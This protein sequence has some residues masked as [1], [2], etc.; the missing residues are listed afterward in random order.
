M[1]L[2]ARGKDRFAQ[3]LQ[4]VTFCPPSRNATGQ[5]C[6]MATF[7][8]TVKYA[9]PTGT[10]VSTALLA[11]GVELQ[12]PQSKLTH[13]WIQAAICY[14][15][16]NW[17]NTSVVR[18][19]EEAVGKESTRKKRLFV[20]LDKEIIDGKELI[21]WHLSSKQI[22]WP[23]SF[24]SLHMSSW[25]NGATSVRQVPCCTGHFWVHS[26]RLIDISFHCTGKHI[27]FTEHH[28]LENT[29][30]RIWMHKANLWPWSQSAHS[31]VK[32]LHQFSVAHN[33]L[34]IFA[35]SSPASLISVWFC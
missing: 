3:E 7:V 5:Q 33:I 21:T 4:N 9:A 14:P 6:M 10:W 30:P 24:T 31:A 35:H 28:S 15:E 8:T 13:V 2:K 32:F 18:K 29:L 26:S 16:W 20:G 11:H 23:I 22:D 34:H 19:L 27:Q 17:N 12:L 1:A 25:R